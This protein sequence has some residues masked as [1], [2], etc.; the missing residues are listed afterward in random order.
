MR[1]GKLNEDGYLIHHRG[2]KQLR[3]HETVQLA[4]A[5]HRSTILSYST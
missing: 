1:M 4:A 2:V 5:Q 3:C